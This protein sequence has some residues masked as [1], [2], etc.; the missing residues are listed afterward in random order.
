MGTEEDQA[1]QELEGNLEHDSWHRRQDGVWD[2]LMNKECESSR[3]I[4][5]IF[6]VVF[7]LAWL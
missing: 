5:V 1:F 7:A 6:V 2:R 3:D 4:R